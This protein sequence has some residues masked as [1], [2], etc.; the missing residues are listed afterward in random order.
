LTIFIFIFIFFSINICFVLFRRVFLVREKKT[1]DIY[2]M[3]VI[4]K[5][6]AIKKNTLDKIVCER[7]ILLKAMNRYVVT[8]YYSFQSDESL[9]FVMEY[10]PGG[11]LGSLIE[12]LGYLD[13]EYA[14]IYVVSYFSFFFLFLQRVFVY[15]MSF[16]GPNCVGFGAHT[17]V[18][19]FFVF[20]FVALRLLPY[21]SK[22]IIHRD[23][24]PDS[25][26]IK[27]PSFYA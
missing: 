20:V 24:K 27:A 6:D 7:D 9:Y 2:A 26:H 18:S 1:R 4:R 15:F 25:M 23:I 16:L 10:L 14:R 13:E 22:G 11:D 12:H 21:F 17:Q 19:V 8:L 5:K 3:K